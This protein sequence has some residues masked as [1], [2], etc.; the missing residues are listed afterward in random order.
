M[1]SLHFRRDRETPFFIE[2]SSSGGPTGEPW[3]TPTKSFVAYWKSYLFYNIYLFDSDR[4][5]KYFPVFSSLLIDWLIDRLHT[6]FDF[7]Q[8][9]WLYS[10]W[11][12]FVFSKFFKIY[13]IKL[14]HFSLLKIMMCTIVSC[15]DACIHTIIQNICFQF[16]CFHKC[17]AKGFCH[18]RLAVIANIFLF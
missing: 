2:K 8:K 9:K 15:V 10:S 4:N 1:V 18:E 5:L 6:C 17:F 16:G 12:A 13:F 3:G 11:K 14:L 7:F